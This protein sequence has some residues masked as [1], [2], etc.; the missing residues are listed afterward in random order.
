MFPS[1]S[2]LYYLIPYTQYYKIKKKKTRI[3][4]TVYILGYLYIQ[5]G[6]R[7]YN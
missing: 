1:T 4:V 3:T 7:H 6:S 2:C 5:D